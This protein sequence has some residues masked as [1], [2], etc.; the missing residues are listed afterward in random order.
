MSNSKQ[1]GFAHLVL[2]IIVAAVVVIG[3]TGIYVYHR[4]RRAKATTVNSSASSSGKTS[5]TTK[6]PTITDPYAG[7]TTASLQYEKMSFKYPS[8][9]QISNTSKDEQATG[10]TATPG[11]DT[12]LLTSPTGMVVSIATG[13]AGI[14]DGDGIDSV[15]PGGQ[16]ISTLGGNYYL[17]FYTNTA[18]SSTD[19]QGACLDKATTATGAPYIASKN[20]RLANIIAPAADVNNPTADV[21]CIQYQQVNGQTP[22][23]AVSTFENDVSFNDAKLIIESLTY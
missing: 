7:W 6:T 1:L 14:G 11:A 20:I 21:V 13:I 8:S 12:A 3:G 19:A 4:D 18:I 17:D 16:P 22:E 23:K 15:L 2:P 5:T 9:W 10:G